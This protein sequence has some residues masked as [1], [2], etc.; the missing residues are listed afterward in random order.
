MYNVLD[1]INAVLIMQ[2]NYAIAS[3]VSELADI[4]R[5]NLKL[6]ETMITLDEEMTIISKFV[7]I[8]KFRLNDK[9]NVQYDI[10]E[11][12]LNIKLPKFILQPLVENSIFH[13]NINLLST[14]DIINVVIS[15]KEENDNILKNSFIKIR[16]FM[17]IFKILL[18]LFQKVLYNILK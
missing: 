2:D 1:S 4:M 3:I 10:C 13:S 17:V 16:I 5:Y 14:D 7:N 11:E 9:L 6:T 12:I 8:Q 18:Y 15:A